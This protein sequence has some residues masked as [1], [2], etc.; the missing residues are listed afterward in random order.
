MTESTTNTMSQTTETP[1]DLGATVLPENPSANAPATA[2]A[3][4]P[5]VPRVPLHKIYA[6]P[7]PIR[8]FPLPSFYPSNPIS[9]FHLVYAWLSQVFR[10]PP[11]EPSVIHVGQWDPATR[12]VHVKEPKSI[13]ALWEQGFFGK[14]SLSRSEPNWLKR[15][16]GRRGTTSGITVSE[17]RTELRREER[18]QAKWDRAK[19]ELE[20]IERQRQVEAQSSVQAVKAVVDANPVP[21]TTQDGPV[22]PVSVESTVISVESKTDGLRIEETIVVNGAEAVRSQVGPV[23]ILALPNS[24]SLPVRQDMTKVD[25]NE[26]AI[27]KDSNQSGELGEPWV[28][29]DPA[30]TY[31][32]QLNGGLYSDEPVQQ[33]SEGPK[34]P[35]GPAELLALPNSAATSPVESKSSTNNIL[36]GTREELKSPVGPLELLSLPN[37]VVLSKPASIKASIQDTVQLGNLSTTPSLSCSQSNGQEI[38]NVDDGSAQSDALADG[39]GTQA[40]EASASTNGE[41]VVEKTRPLKRKAVNGIDSLAL[42]NGSMDTAQSPKEGEDAVKRRKTVRFS[43]RVQSTTFQRF[44]PPTPNRSPGHSPQTT[45]PKL[46]S[47]TGSPEVQTATALAVTPSVGSVN[48]AAPTTQVNLAEV[49]NKEHFQLAPEEAFFLVFALGAL[50]VLDPDTNKPISPG[51]LLTLFR[52]NSYFPPKPLDSLAGALQ[53]HDPFLLQYAVYH[54]YRSLGWVPRHGIKFG[55]DWILYQRGPVFDHSEF[56]LM[57]MPSFSD[58]RWAGYEHETPKRSWSWLMGVNRVLAHVLKGLVLVYVDVP[59][60]PIFEEAMRVG[61]IAAALKKYTVREVMVRRFSVNRNR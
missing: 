43:P 56:G 30:A 32:E 53:P 61:G 51:R 9:L 35:V 33:R 25:H 2:T 7:A 24:A 17:E 23:E 60:P 28:E 54:H 26:V 50:T 20:A 18:R 34:A 52:A 1:K 13:R 47:E 16:E 44:D 15:E 6:L 19:A 37:S 12:S 58:P 38:G 45:S 49:V 29:L 22:E 41:L 39:T 48:N 36:D 8:T 10:P 42:T 59:P 46:T 55:V 57:T 11:A 3:P 31:P 14:G 5:F 40:N 27:A 4:P 21:S